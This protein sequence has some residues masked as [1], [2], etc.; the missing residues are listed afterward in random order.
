M[1]YENGSKMSE[2]NYRNGLLDGISI[3]YYKNG[4]TK[5]SAYFKGLLHGESSN[6]DKDGTLVKGKLLLE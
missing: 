4:K 2:A 6:W 5:A 1:Y 3:S